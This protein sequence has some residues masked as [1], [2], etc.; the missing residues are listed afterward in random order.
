VAAA[1]DGDCPRPMLPL[2]SL[3]ASVEPDGER[4]F[5]QTIEIARQD[6]ADIAPADMLAI[7]ADVER[8]V[9]DSSIDGVVVTHGSDTLEETAFVCDLL[10]HS[11]KPVVF[12]AALRL[13][14]EL[15][16][17]GPRNLRAAHRVAGD[18]RVGE[19]GVVV[20]ANDDVHAARW[21]QKTDTFR[22]SAFRSPGHGPVGAVLPNAISLHCSPVPLIP[23]VTPLGELPAVA[24]L[25]AFTGMPPELPLRIVAEC[26][27]QGLVIQGFG[28]GNLP[29]ALLPAIRRLIADGV[30]VV[31]AA[32]PS[33][34]GTHPVYGGGG[35]G[36][37]KAE[38]VLEGKILT[39]RKARLLLMIALANDRAAAA[40]L[41]AG[42]AARM[43]GEEECAASA[44]AG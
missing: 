22:P 37:L 40:D 29:E 25:P 5:T 35:V 28:M 4:L 33:V 23:I 17:D 12:T 11:P 3:V 41:F 34:G 15:G 13:P 2:A 14:E 21:V 26:D 44:P 8:V 42:Y 9:G 39:A 19:L 30:Q 43:A 31:V 36:A 18:R 38:G 10:V 6:S 7:A 32:G 16:A 1:L 20:V 27:A 24:I